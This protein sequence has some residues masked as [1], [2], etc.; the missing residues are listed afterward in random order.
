M[1][2]IL[3]PISPL[4][5]LIPIAISVFFIWATYRGVKELSGIYARLRE[6]RDRL[7]PASEVR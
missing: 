2:L 7:P 3:A 6:I 1:R 4:F 5:N